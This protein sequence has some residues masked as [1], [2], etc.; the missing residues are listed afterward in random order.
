[1]RRRGV[2][3]QAQYDDE[4]NWEVIVNKNQLL[5]IFINLFIN[6]IDA[7]PDGGQLS[8]D[9]LLE[10]PEHKKQDYLAIRVIDTGVGIKKEHLSRIFDR[11]YTSKDT[12][13]GLGL[14]VVERIISAHSGTL[15]VASEEGKG[16]T[17]T[18]YFPYNN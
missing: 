1:M 2:K 14:A 9:G 10:Q 11:Y 17:F 12:G 4:V 7:M 5:E 16:T 13:T 15:H 8:V 3:F 6:A 18:V